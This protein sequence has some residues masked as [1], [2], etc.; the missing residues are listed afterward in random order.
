MTELRS[1]LDFPCS[2]WLRRAARDGNPSRSVS[3]VG[4]DV[5]RTT[6]VFVQL[7]PDA[8]ADDSKKVTLGPATL[9]QYLISS[10]LNHTLTNVGTA[11]SR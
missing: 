10:S 1:R 3:V 2:Y 5:N 7:A 4:L 9:K 6:G 8:D 11:P